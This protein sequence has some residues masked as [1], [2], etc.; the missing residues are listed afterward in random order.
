MLVV[1]HRLSSLFYCRHFCVPRSA[2]PTTAADAFERALN[3]VQKFVARKARKY[4]QQGG[5]LAL[6]ALEFAYFFLGIAHAPRGVI[7]QRMLPLVDEQL[8]SIRKH[9]E[10]PAK[11]ATGTESG[12]EEYW[13]DLALANLLRGICLRFVAYPDAD[14]V[15]EAEE[16]KAVREGRAEAEKGA[17]EAFEAVF[18]DGPRIA[19]DHYLVY[20]SRECFVLR[21]GGWCSSDVSACRLRVCAAFGVP[22]RQG[23]RS[24][25]SRAGALW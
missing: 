18:K 20:Y 14:A 17:A 2:Q 6:P 24:E 21:L 8:A 5:R 13:D 23:G 15:L 7:R 19:Y 9:A 12:E 25:A 22:G 4:K 10:E 11:Y 3:V 16:E 1:R